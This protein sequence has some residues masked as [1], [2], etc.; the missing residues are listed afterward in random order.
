MAS[1]GRNADIGIR[2]KYVCAYEKQ[3]HSGSRPAQ[4]PHKRRGRKARR[5]SDQP[6][7]NRGGGGSE[8]AVREKA[9]F[10]LKSTDGKSIALLRSPPDHAE[11]PGRTTPSLTPDTTNDAIPR[12]TQQQIQVQPPARTHARAPSPA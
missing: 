8:R 10:L 6:T 9:S 12:P 7:K 2:K 3:N 1:T 11:P 5:A 4:T